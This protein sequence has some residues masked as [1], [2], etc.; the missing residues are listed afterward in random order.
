L[1]TST[2]KKNDSDQTNFIKYI[3]NISDLEKCKLIPIPP[4]TEIR[5]QDNG[6]GKY[7]FINGSGS[8]KYFNFIFTFKIK[9]DSATSHNSSMPA[10]PAAS[11]KA[12]RLIVEKKITF[13]L[14]TELQ[15]QGSKLPCG[16]TNCFFILK[17]DND[18]NKKYGLRISSLIY[19]ENDTELKNL[20]IENVIN[21]V[22]HYYS[23]LVKKKDNFPEISE[24]L[25]FGI[26]KVTFTIDGKPKNGYIPYTLT[27]Y[28]PN[29]MQLKQYINSNLLKKTQCDIYLFITKLLEKIYNFYVVMRPYFKFSH[30]DFKTDNILID[31]E[32][33]QIYIIDFG[34]AQ[35]NIYE[36]D[37]IYC[38]RNRKQLSLGEPDADSI[39]EEYKWYVQ[40]I[41]NVFYSDNDI[42]LLIWWLVNN[43]P[44]QM[45][46]HEIKQYNNSV[47][48]IFEFF[49]DIINDFSP[50]IGQETTT[51]GKQLIKNNMENFS[52]SLLKIRLFQIYQ[53]LQV[54]Q[55]VKEKACEYREY[56]PK[57]IDYNTDRFRM[58]VTD[59]TDEEILTSDEDKLFRLISKAQNPPPVPVSGGSKTKKQNHTYIQS[60]RNKSK[61]HKKPHNRNKRKNTS[62]NI[63]YSRKIYKN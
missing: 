35:I 58:Y 21:S 37:A 28:N 3:N 29:N 26:I 27:N 40:N 7:F 36:G 51:L 10:I 49:K 23:S 56:I 9:T 61:I 17:D 59:F 32:T 19:F 50:P 18:E 14:E 11:P 24:I 45:E 53:T 12:E 20:I 30:F 48:R 57:L 31:S 34:H 52:G 1:N 38:L 8:E 47:M 62:K 60:N 43:F 46:T 22:C 2:L 54:K 41:N 25:K 63:K 55:D 5:L 16:A 15:L 4:E 42:E 44:K 33:Q 6:F 39:S 13:N